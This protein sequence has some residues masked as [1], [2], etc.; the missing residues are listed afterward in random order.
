MASSLSE[1][2]TQSKNPYKLHTVV[3]QP[4]SQTSA[5]M[6]GVLRLRQPIRKRMDWLRSG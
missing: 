1:E 6:L 4:A 2:A 3:K 5:K